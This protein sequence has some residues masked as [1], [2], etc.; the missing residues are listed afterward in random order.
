MRLR[1]PLTAQFLLL[2]SLLGAFGFLGYP[3]LPSVLSFDNV[4]QA[5]MILLFLW[6]AISAQVNSRWVSYV[7]LPVLATGA[8][9]LLYAFVFTTRV[10][11]PLLPSV[12]AQRYYVFVLLGPVVYLLHARGWD[13]FD[14][15]RVFLLAMF[16]SMV[17]FVA[18]DLTVSPI[19]V[20]LSGQFLVLHLGETYQDLGNEL[21]GLNTI[22]LFLLLYYVRRLSKNTG[23]VVSAV[24]LAMIALCVLLLVITV[25]RALLLSAGM[26]L[27]L[28]ALFLSRPTR[29]KLL[30]VMLPL[31]AT[32]LGF[33]LP[34][35]RDAFLRT[36][37][38]DRTYRARVDEIQIAWQAFREY[39]LFGFGQDSVNTVS[40]QDVFG[41]LYP[42]DMGIIG[43]A[44]Q[45]GLLGVLLY[46]AFGVWLCVNLLNLRW[47]LADGA[48]PR[49]SAFLW[50]LLL[51]CLTFLISLP[52]EAKFIFPYGYGLPIAAFSWGLLMVYKHGWS[53]HT[54]QAHTAAAKPTVTAAQGTAPR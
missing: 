17:A 47:A 12:L 6:L 8:F 28:Y 1:R 14:F 25:P 22:T 29:A 54:A 37:G 42:A 19:S 23:A 43:V 39:P 36:F 50:A 51:I 46:T 48:S 4:G 35:L 11:A 33:L 9:I 20:L 2:M 31:Y 7:L 52:L 32:I 18:C 53:T 21:R 16:L 3:Y 26:A 27:V 38:E 5:C 24:A 15:Q 30:V 45:F 34:S 40:Y 44:F 10:D 49:Q 41:H 13:L